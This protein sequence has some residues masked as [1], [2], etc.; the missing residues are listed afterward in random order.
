[1]RGA[2]AEVG[3]RGDAPTAVVTAAAVDVAAAVTAMAATVAAAATVAPIEPVIR[4]VHRPWRWR[5]MDPFTW[6]SPSLAP[7]YRPCLVE[8][9][10][11]MGWGGVGP[12]GT[13]GCGSLRGW[14]QA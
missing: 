2:P 11:K 13:Q 4:A 8:H 14:R 1:M 7:G 6:D 12:R 9:E 10:R 5:S 3:R